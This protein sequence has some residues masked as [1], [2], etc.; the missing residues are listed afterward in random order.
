MKITKLL[1][2]ALPALLM[3]STVTIADEGRYQAYWNGKSYMILDSD[4][5]HMWTYFGDTIMYN[6]KIDG[7]EFKSPEKT[8]IWQQSHGK[9]VKK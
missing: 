2:F 6:G 7:D 8:K 3:T 9:W 4:R 5:G 1:A